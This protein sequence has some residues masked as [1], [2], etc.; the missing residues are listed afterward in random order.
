MTEL[1]RYKI[2]FPISV[3]AMYARMAGGIRK[4]KRYKAWKKEAGLE[5]MIQRPRPTSGP[6]TIVLELTAPD[7]RRR[8]ADNLAKSV[9]DLLVTQRVIADDNQQFVRWVKPE[10]V[11]STTPGCVIVIAQAEDVP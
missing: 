4:S 2:P 8:D 1:A 5:M 7:D 11:K 3:N 10:W 9:L 6:V